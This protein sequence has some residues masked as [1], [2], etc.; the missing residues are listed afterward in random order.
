MNADIDAI[1]HRHAETSRLGDT[2]SAHQDRGVLLAEVDRLTAELAEARDDY[3]AVCR[4]VGCYLRG[5]ISTE[6]ET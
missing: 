3:D 6:N 4:S 5:G 1:R 2:G